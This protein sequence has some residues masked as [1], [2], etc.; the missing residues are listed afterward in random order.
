MWNLDKFYCRCLAFV[1]SCYKD[2]GGSTLADN[3]DSISFL[4]DLFAVCNVPCSYHSARLVITILF[5][6]KFQR[7]VVCE[8]LVLVSENDVS[9]FKSEKNVLELKHKKEAG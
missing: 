3:N 4:V 1:A 7:I 6:F 9:M 2:D 5:L 8:T